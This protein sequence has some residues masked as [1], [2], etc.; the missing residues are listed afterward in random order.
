MKDFRK[1]IKLLGFVWT[2]AKG[3]QLKIVIGFA[4]GIVLALIPAIV[5]FAVK[6]NIDNN[7]NS[8]AQ[9]LNADEL[10]KFTIIIA[11]GVIC[12][13]IIKVLHGIAMPAIKRNVDM[14]YIRKISSMPYSYIADKTDSSAIM[15]VSIE[16]DMIASLIPVIYN[17]FIKAPITVAAFIVV[18]I[19]SSIKLTIIAVV[20][21]LMIAIGVLLCRN[22]IKD[23]T[24]ECYDKIG[25]M[26]RLFNEMLTG[27]KVFV[28][29]DSMNFM[30]KRLIRMSEN[31]C[32]LKQ[33]VTK[34]NATQSFVVEAVTVAI[35]I[36]FIIVAKNN[37]TMS[38]TFSITNLILFP[39]AILYIRSEVL[40]IVYGYGQLSRTESATKRVMNIILKKDDIDKREIA[41]DEKIESLTLKNITFSYVEGHPVLNDLTCEFKK[42]GV[43]CIVGRSGEG[44]TTLLNIC[45]GLRLPDKGNVIYNKIDIHEGIN[46]WIY[47]KIALIEQEPFIFEGSISDNIFLGRKEDSEKALQM[48]RTLQL[49]HLANTVD[50]LH[51]TMIGGRYRKLSTGEKQRL[52]VVRAAIRDIDVIF[53]DEATSNID[54]NNTKILI[55]FINE[56]AKEKLIIS[57]SHD[58]SFISNSTNVVVLENGKLRR[59]C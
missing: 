56:L 18:L 2:M 44:K 41:V 37:L 28:V 49:Q 1:E 33:K 15:G 34:V 39:T 57:V 3:Q 23:T 53:L 13:L 14:A 35:T 38:Q 36:T 42:N 54:T 9:L 17:S 10:M 32:D 29:S 59:I 19:V 7:N 48:L 46:T 43:N 25:G 47:K 20:L 11:S 16:S 55:D 22:R 12:S 21:A 40:K 50:E 51:T 8:I 5:A 26:H 27:Y 4:V 52:A 24:K 6:D 58:M 45:M 31:I 30:K